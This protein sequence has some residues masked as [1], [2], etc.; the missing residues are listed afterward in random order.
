MDPTL[1]HRSCLTEPFFIEL[2]NLVLDITQNGL[3]TRIDK[4]ETQQ[5]NT[6]ATVNELVQANVALVAAIDAVKVDAK[7]DYDFIVS[8]IARLQAIID[9]QPTPAQLDEVLAGTTAATASI[10]SF[11]L[12]PTR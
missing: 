3:N 2:L 7:E 1:Q 11:D 8:E 9:A 12:D 5:E 10:A 6:M 4:L